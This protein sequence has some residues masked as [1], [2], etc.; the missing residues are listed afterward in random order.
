MS[1]IKSI[2]ITILAASFVF[3][4]AFAQAEEV[5]VIEV[6][7][8][9]KLGHKEGHY[10]GIIGVTDENRDFV[11]S[12]IETG[13]LV[14]GQQIT[15]EGKGCK[16]E[17]WPLPKQVPVCGQTSVRIKDANGNKTTTMVD[18]SEFDGPI[19]VSIISNGGIPL[20][21]D[22]PD[23]TPRVNEK[24]WPKA[25]TINVLGISQ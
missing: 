14:V 7:C 12:L 11:R 5:T 19:T 3:F 22:A 20:G 15:L 6:P 18:N 4:A 1:P 17:N 24:R 21:D 8:L 13:K 10:K 25:I 2:N 9:C 16:A 23:G